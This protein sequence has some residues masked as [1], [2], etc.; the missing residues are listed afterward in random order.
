MKLSRSLITAFL[1]FPLNVMGVIP[2]LLLWCSKPGGVLERFPYSFNNFRSLAGVLLIAEGAGLC[3]KTVSLFTEVGEGTP[4]P[5]DPPRKLVIMGPYVYV[6]NPMM[7]GVWLVL[8]GEALVFGSVPLGLWFLGFCG[9]C[10]ILIPAW[11]EP[12]LKNRFGEPYEEYKRT[13]PR[14]IPKIP[15]KK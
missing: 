3:W 7:L 9:L 10:L 4:A 8:L 13:V 5:Y 1:L 6:R 12:D 2:A 15:L 11:E 14:W